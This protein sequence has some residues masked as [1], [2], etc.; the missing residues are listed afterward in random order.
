[1]RHTAMRHNETGSNPVLLMSD[2]W[3]KISFASIRRGGGG[4]GGVYTLYRGGSG[5]MAVAPGVPNRTMLNLYC[6]E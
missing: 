1:M 2:R 4:G 5:G 6:N 3:L